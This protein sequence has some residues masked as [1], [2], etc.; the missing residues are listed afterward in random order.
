MNKDIK[1]LKSSQ[2]LD[3]YDIVSID[4]PY[5]IEEIECCAFYNCP[6]LQHITISNT[7]KAIGFSA[8]RFCSELDNIVIPDSVTFIGHDAFDNTKWYK[9]NSDDY[10]ILSDKYLIKYS[11]KSEN[12]RIPKSVKYISPYTFDRCIHLKT[13]TIPNGIK[14]IESFSFLGCSNIK[15][16][17]IPNSVEKISEYAF[18]NCKKLES[19][20][21]SENV[22]YISKKAFAGCSE[23]LTV[24]APKNSYGN[25][26]AE[27]NCIEYLEL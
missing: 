24:F 4:I 21:I 15:S 11:G 2:Y 12:A 5:G 26:F 19:V 17:I 13:I 8:F 16:I 27:E 1:K 6:N 3:R 25:K 23:N 10:V 20:S 7:V 9:N 22:K 18:I 14:V